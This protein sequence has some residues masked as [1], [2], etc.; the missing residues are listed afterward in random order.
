MT[1]RLIVGHF[2]MKVSISYK[3]VTVPHTHTTPLTPSLD[4]PCTSIF[5]HPP[6]PLAPPT[7]IFSI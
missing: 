1:K 2:I 3:I 5:I 4:T 6:L 7:N